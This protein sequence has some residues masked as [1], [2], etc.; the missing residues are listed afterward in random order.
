MHIPNFGYL[1]RQHELLRNARQKLLIVRSA[2][3]FRGTVSILLT[4]DDIRPSSS[5]NPRESR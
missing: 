2:L 5:T 3:I 1:D 4:V